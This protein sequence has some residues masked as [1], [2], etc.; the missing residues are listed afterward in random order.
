MEGMR[1]RSPKKSEIKVGFVWERRLQCLP[2]G[3]VVARSLGALV[4]LFCGLGQGQGLWISKDRG[5]L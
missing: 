5:G 1:K 4:E 2:A 3:H